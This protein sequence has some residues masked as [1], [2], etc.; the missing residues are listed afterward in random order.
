MSDS[1]TP[2]DLPSNELSSKIAKRLRARLKA[3]GVE[4]KHTEILHAIAEACGLKDAPTLRALAGAQLPA[5]DDPAGAAHYRTR[6]VF[7]VIS[8]QAPCDA[9]SMEGVLSWASERTCVT[10]LRARRAEALNTGSLDAALAAAG[11]HPETFVD[12]G[13][14]DGDPIPV[15]KLSCYHVRA[16][17]SSHI[18][19]WD[20]LPVH[21]VEC[22]LGGRSVAEAKELA[23]EMLEAHRTWDPRIDPIANIRAFDAGHYDPAEASD[24]FKGLV[25][26]L[27]EAR[28]EDLPD[29]EVPEITPRQVLTF[30]QLN[31]DDELAALLGYPSCF[32]WTRRSL[33][34][35]AA[36]AAAS[37]ET[38]D[39]PVLTD[40]A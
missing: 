11:A 14:I 33:A 28:R 20:D 10:H 39:D 15:G 8:S 9:L 26:G 36:A 24:A 38:W 4:V 34:G 16:W 3:Q 29:D 12:D 21:S 5:Q 31:S 27:S 25:A 23:R 6:Y 35:E 18:G 7:D 37:Q 40:L 19:T 2:A 30:L 32:G 13:P 1:K 22:Y 17:I